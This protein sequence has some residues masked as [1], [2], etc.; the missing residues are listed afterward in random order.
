MRKEEKK[1]Q[2]RHPHGIYM[3]V[4]VCPK[5]A[6]SSFTSVR[7]PTICQIYLPLHIHTLKERN[8]ELVSPKIL[9]RALAH[10]GNALSVVEFS[11]VS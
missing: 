6:S 9:A 1:T 3:C 7:D 8:R 2:I 10:A 11:V 4:C 5:I